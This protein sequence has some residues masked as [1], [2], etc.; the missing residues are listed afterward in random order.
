MSSLFQY[1]PLAA[2][3]L[4]TG[5]AA[6]GLSASVRGTIARHLIVRYLI[7][8]LAIVPGVALIGFVLGRR[9]ESSNLFDFLRV[10][11]AFFLPTSPLESGR[12]EPLSLT[13]CDVRVRF[14]SPIGST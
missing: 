6:H 1:A 8:A 7:E 2:V 14:H 12:A 13:A 9:G 5:F 4:I 11:G 10:G 3:G